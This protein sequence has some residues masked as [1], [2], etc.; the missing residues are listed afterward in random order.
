MAQSIF[1]RWFQA[2]AGLWGRVVGR[3]PPAE[4]GP[5][6]EGAVLDIA[7]LLTPKGRPPPV[8]LYEH[9]E[10]KAHPRA[11]ELMPEGL[12]WDVGAKNAPFGSEE[13]WASLATFRKWRAKHPN[14]SLRKCLEWIIDGWSPV[15]YDDTMLDN[16]LVYRQL[17]D[18]EMHHEVNELD[19]TIISTALGQL[20]FE[21]SIDDDAKPLV[22]LA[23]ARQSLPAVADFVAGNKLA[24]AYLPIIARVVGRA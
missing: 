12:F 6:R 15:P 13:G 17:H 24:T 4:S 1:E 16:T 23:L 5:L 20:I 21:G 19:L 10:E 7:P 11:R 3:A 22:R 18:E 8:I 2:I 14:E 9:G